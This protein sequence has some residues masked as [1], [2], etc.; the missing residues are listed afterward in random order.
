MIIL[1][2]FRPDL[3]KVGPV[4]HIQ[5]AACPRPARVRPF[6]NYA[7]YRSIAKVVWPA[8][9]ERNLSAISLNKPFLAL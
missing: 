2:E 3:G 9:M 8:R 6:F 5:P 7:I 1:N 4:G